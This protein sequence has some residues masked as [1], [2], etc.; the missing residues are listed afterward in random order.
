MFVARV[1]PRA[2]AAANGLR[3]GVAGLAA[4]AAVA[5]PRARWSSSSSSSTS[6]PN[7]TYLNTYGPLALAALLSGVAGYFL[8]RPSSEPKKAAA[9]PAD[10]H[11][12]FNEEYG[13][14]EDFEKAIGELRAALPGEGVSTEEEVLKKHGM[15]FGVNFIPRASQLR[16]ALHRDAS[17]LTLTRTWGR[18]D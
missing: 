6:D 1:L 8:A 9:E 15:A 7:A 14:H 2:N 18:V 11:V 16:S 4:R 10:A 17:E 12:K 13:T 5:R 3:A